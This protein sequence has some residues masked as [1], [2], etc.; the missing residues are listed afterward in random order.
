M[1]PNIRCTVRRLNLVLV[2]VH[3]CKAISVA[4]QFFARLIGSCLCLYVEQN[5]HPKFLE[6]QRELCLNRNPQQLR[7]ITETLHADQ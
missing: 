6:T 4:F 5:F 3:V 7:C 1:V 2:D